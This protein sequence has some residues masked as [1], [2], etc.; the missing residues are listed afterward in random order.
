MILH[1][2]L[3]FLLFVDFMHDSNFIVQTVKSIKLCFKKY[4]IALKNNLQFSKMEVGNLFIFLVS[5][6]LLLISLPFNF[7]PKNN[8][9][10][11]LIS[12]NESE[13]VSG[14]Y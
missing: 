8:R 14:H 6:T 4:K 10:S 11:H 5:W 1:S 2:I 3:K 13:T 12:R 9:N 7:S